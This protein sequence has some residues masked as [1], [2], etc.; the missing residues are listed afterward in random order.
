MT[1]RLVREAQEVF[2]PV[3]EQTKGNDGYVSF[4]LDPL[5]ERS[6]ERD[7]P[8]AERVE[9]VHRAGQAVVGRARRTG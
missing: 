5:L 2:L 6:R 9:A 4:E 7:L 3:W 1:D 8:H